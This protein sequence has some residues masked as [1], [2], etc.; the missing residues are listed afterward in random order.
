M[1]WEVLP[2]SSLFQTV[3]YKSG[4][5]EACL[6]Y[7]ILCMCVYFRTRPDRLWGPPSL[8]YNG[9][10]VFLPGVKRLGRGV[11]HPPPSSAEVK[12]RI[13]L[14]LYSP[15]GPSWPV[16]EW[17]LPLPLPSPIYIY[18]YIWNRQIRA[19]WDVCGRVSICC[20]CAR[21]VLVC[22]SE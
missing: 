5:V 22:L 13:E 4:I 8:P 12:E 1:R 2:L 14:Y 19:P 3:V 11:D 16:L 21:C 10:R 6:Y 15:A 9:Y 18:I 17:T 7:R 20:D